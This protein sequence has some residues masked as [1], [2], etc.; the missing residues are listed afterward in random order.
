MKIIVNYRRLILSALLF[1]Y[2]LFLFFFSEICIEG[3]K[4]GLLLWFEQ[5]LPS[6]LPFLI[7]SGLCVRFHLTETIG[8]IFY[9]IL[10]IL[11]VSKQG[12][13][14]VVLGLLSGY[15]AGAKTCADMYRE[16][17]LSQREASFLLC[18]CNN[19]SPMFLMG[20][21]S[22]NCLGLPEYRYAIF[23][24]IVLSGI[25]SALILYPVFFR[26]MP[27]AVL[28]DQMPAGKK[29]TLTVMQKLDE[30]ILSSF[31]VMVKV[32]GYIIL[33]SI[34]AKLLSHWFSLLPYRSFRSSTLLSTAIL[35]S[36]EISVGAAASGNAMLPFL[37]KIA[38]T[39]S[40]CAFGG[41]SALAQTKSV[42]GSSGLSL[43][44]YVISKLLQAVLAGMI[45]YGFF[46][47][48]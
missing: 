5:I 23:S 6:L 41:L 46:F 25:F 35:G 29:D 22:V 12:C 47:F 4:D 43:K 9:P 42:I 30:T 27:S 45:G 33:F 14:P 39:L 20:F 7:L 18:L 16:G 3:A 48:F 26:K 24:I 8:K 10:R 32:G 17:K 1:T 13:Y 2:L 15:P 44:Y 36:M 28:S 31:E 34:P 38:L 19:A 37:T 21:V 40:V 11:P